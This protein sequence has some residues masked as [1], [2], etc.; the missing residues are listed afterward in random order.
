MLSWE[1]VYRLFSAWTTPGKP[2]AYS[3]TAGTSRKPPM[4]EPQ[5]QTKTPVRTGSSRDVTLRRI[6]RLARQRA[7]CRRQ[8]AAGACGRAAG[9]DDRLGDVLGLTE[10]ADGE[11]AR[12]GGLE[13]IELHGVAEAILV[14]LDAQLSAQRLHA[15]G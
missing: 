13:R 4:L 9:L 8:Q 2:E 11:D 12:P 3:A 7:A 5:W 10:R 14:E 6:L 15:P 1:Q